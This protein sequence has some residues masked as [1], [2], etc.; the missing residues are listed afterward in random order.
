MPN[1]YSNNGNCSASYGGDNK[2]LYYRSRY[3]DGYLYLADTLY[4]PQS[5]TYEISVNVE[6]V[7]IQNL[8]AVSCS[9]QEREDG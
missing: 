7:T 5:G 8:I 6:C 9:W 2:Y 4:A 3:Y 1:F